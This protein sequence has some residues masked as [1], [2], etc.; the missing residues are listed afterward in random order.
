MNCSP[1]IINQE[2]IERVSTLKC[3]DLSWRKKACIFYILDNVSERYYVIFQLSII[4]ILQSDIIL[5][6]CAIILTYPCAVCHIADYLLD[7][8]ISSNEC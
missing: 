1:V 4:G 5:V 2:L 7:S 8:Q 6:Y 3:S